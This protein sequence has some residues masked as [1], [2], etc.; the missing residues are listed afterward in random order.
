ML[1]RQR[2]RGE[3]GGRR[4]HADF[5]R[6]SNGILRVEEA[7]LWGNRESTSNVFLLYYIGGKMKEEVEEGKGSAERLVFESGDGL[8]YTFV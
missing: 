3:R 8:E 1:G 6:K 4:E 5:S 2:R 7:V